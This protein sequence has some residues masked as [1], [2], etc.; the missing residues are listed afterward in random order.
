M[1]R[2]KRH[3]EAPRAE[4]PR[5]RTF[6]WRS[7]IWVAGVFAVLSLL[8][9]GRGIFGQ[10]C[11]YRAARDIDVLAL[12][13]AQK[14][15]DRA[16]RLH[17]RNPE[18]ELMRTQCFR[19]LRD[20]KRHDAAL[21]LAKKYGA[22]RQ[23]VQNEITLAKFQT[24]ELG[25][26]ASDQFDKLM[27]AGISPHDTSASFISGSI[28]RKNRQLA[29]VMLDA[30]ERDSPNHPHVIFF[31]GVLCGLSNDNEGARAAF[32]KS[33]AIEPRHELARLALAR[34]SESQNQFA[35]AMEL[36]LPLAET[37]P[38]NDMIAAGFARSLRMTGRLAQAKSVL[39][40]L[41]SQPDVLASVI[42][43]MVHVELE[44]GNYR[45]A[46][47]WF[48]QAAPSFT[49]DD[50]MLTAA[51]ITLSMLGETIASDNLLTAA[52]DRK[53]EKSL[54]D[55]LKT[56]LAVNPQDW[57]AAAQLQKSIGQM[58]AR[59]PAEGPYASA[60]LKAAAQLKS[61]SP[62]RQLY[63]Q[64][65]N[66]CHGLHGDATGYAARHVFPRPR[67][68]RAEPMRLVSTQNGVPT[69][70]D[71]RT[72][73]KLG[74][75]GTS[76]VPL[77]MLSQH[78]LDLLVEVVLQMRREG[79]REQYIA[80]LQA[81]EEPVDDDD[82]SEVVQLRTTPGEVVAAPDVGHADNESLAL[83]EQL[84]VQQACPSCHGET[85]TGDQTMPLFDIAGR[86]DFP[87][88]LVHD[89]F[90]G[91]N[92]PDS[93]YLRILL[94]M[95]GTPHPANVNMTTQ[96]LIALTHYCHSLGE[97]PK[98]TL[99]NHQCAI[100]ASRRPVVQWTAAPP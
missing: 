94:G 18:T 23:A 58:D 6:R 24:G 65:C 21:E 76:M 90:K 61:E 5:R 15:L 30:W 60:L 3:R 70:D 80:S 39:E 7:V 13:D 75:P 97:E 9:L 1:A 67:D 20:T 40:P 53:A 17:P 64:H 50:D 32:Q 59:S 99:T 36:F 73:I 52:F 54:V 55:D 51:G 4:V 33:L 26:E 49:T 22:S 71:I 68:L 95:P 56:R 41:A 83:G 8:V 14:W 88:D 47:S 74:V 87:R 25:E 78:E 85:G 10:W 42:V 77:D 93:I 31:R 35:A 57:R 43:E 100:Q 89:V 29:A 72:V 16:D 27:E 37:H 66:A 81:D 91:G 44:L 86:P 28:A 38:E 48:D 2:T 98:H 19:Q 96:Q 84:Y 92:Q 62:G 45:A 63:L 82:V 46:K 79:V 11:R 34:M 12:G 69:P